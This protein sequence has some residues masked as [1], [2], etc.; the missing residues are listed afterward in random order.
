MKGDLARAEQ[1]LATLDKVCTF[2]CAEYTEL[3]RSIARHKSGPVASGS[4]SASTY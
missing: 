1:R 4:A 3:K 2:G